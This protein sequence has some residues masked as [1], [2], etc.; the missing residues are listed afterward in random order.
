[1]IDQKVQ[2]PITV[3][4]ETSEAFHAVE[5]FRITFCPR[6]QKGGCFE[7]KGVVE[8]ARLPRSAQEYIGS[9]MSTNVQLTAM[10]REYACKYGQKPTLEILRRTTVKE[11]FCHQRVNRLTQLR[12]EAGN[13]VQVIDGKKQELIEKRVYHLSSEHPKPGNYLATGWVKSH[14]KTQQVTFLID[15]LTPLEDDYEAFDLPA[16]IPSLRAVQIND[17]EQS[18]KNPASQPVR[19]ALDLLSP[20]QPSQRRKCGAMFRHEAITA[21]CDWRDA[22]NILK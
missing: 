7:C 13:I 1:V 17:G 19:R 12:D 9:C 16:A 18:Q 5:E 8:P 22:G 14:P 21:L 10:L 15:S 3:C 2:V 6:M 11:F 4:G 20:R